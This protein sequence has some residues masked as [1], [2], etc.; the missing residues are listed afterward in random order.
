MNAYDFGFSYGED[1]RE[2]ECMF[3]N[4]DYSMFDDCTTD[5]DTLTL[6]LTEPYDPVNT[7]LSCGAVPVPDSYADTCQGGGSAAAGGLP[8]MTLYATAFLWVL[9]KFTF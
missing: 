7:T 6:V 9:K 8:M 4:I 2:L 3:G 5:P 1:G